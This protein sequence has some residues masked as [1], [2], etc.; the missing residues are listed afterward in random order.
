MFSHAYRVSRSIIRGRVFNEKTISVD[1][2]H[3]TTDLRICPNVG[4]GLITNFLA[5][6][7]HPA[8]MSPCVAL[9]VQRIRNEILGVSRD[10]STE[11]FHRFPFQPID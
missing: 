7:F 8:Q 4:V 6:A 5:R 9:L 3:R 2:L 1:E 10:G 11:V